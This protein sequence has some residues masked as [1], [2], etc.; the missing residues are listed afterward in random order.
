RQIAAQRD[1]LGEL[2]S[3]GGGDLDSLT[4]IAEL[5]VAHEELTVAESEMRAQQE[6]I[7]ELLAEHADERQWRDR[8]SA[9]LPVAVVVTTVDGNIRESNVAA[10]V[11][12]RVR[13]T[14]LPPLPTFVA[15]DDRARFRSALV[16]LAHGEDQRV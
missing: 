2:T 15:I 7:S 3:D 12:F 11:L 6:Q 4:L 5:D 16:G 13:G 1:R 8:L 14:T 9:A 10:R